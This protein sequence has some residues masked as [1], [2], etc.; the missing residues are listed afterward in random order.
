MASLYLLLCGEKQAAQWHASAAHEHLEGAGRRGRLAAVQFA[1]ALMANRNI[2]KAAMVLAEQVSEVHGKRSSDEKAMVVLADGILKLCQGMQHDA[3]RRFN[4]AL[5]MA[6][7]TMR[8]TQLL[9]QCMLLI[10][11]MAVRND[12][13]AAMENLQ[14]SLQLAREIGALQT[15]V[16][17]AERMSEHDTTC[18]GRGEQYAQ[19]KRKR[20]DEVRCSATNSNEHERIVHLGNESFRTSK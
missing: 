4:S 2:K 9:A 6:R 13:K 15:V 10:G 19:K 8:S 20:Y 16:A 14:A 5:S 1:M 7:N 3:K 11:S 12:T 17:A 18:G